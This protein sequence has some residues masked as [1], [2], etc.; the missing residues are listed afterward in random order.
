MAAED[1]GLLEDMNFN[2]ELESFL[3]NPTP[4]LGAPAPMPTVS[5]DVPKGTMD[6]KI[7][8]ESSAAATAA[9]ATAA[10]GA[11]AGAA[12]SALFGGGKGDGK[13]AVIGEVVGKA[14]EGALPTSLAPVKERAGAFLSKAQSWR[15][16]ALP[17]SVPSAAEA[18]TRLTG[19]MY[20]FQTNYAILYVLNLLLTIFW[21]PSA[22]FSIG[23][24]ILVWIAFLKKNDDPDW[25]PVINGVQLG[26]TQRFLALASTTALVLLLLVGGTI[27][28]A[29]FMFLLFVGLH[30][31][32][33]DPSG[34]AVPGAAADVE[35]GVP[36]ADSL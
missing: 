31:V 11:V 32:L 12:A 19:N 8:E 21:Q 9:A 27:L 16:F 14:V 36:S 35:S 10:V 26:P 22:L 24:S 25:H 6:G 18:C 28:H 34:Y 29:T 13:N 5:L 15:A 20:V 3:N 1:N 30:G 4:T 17:L 23:G 7:E 2:A 33:H